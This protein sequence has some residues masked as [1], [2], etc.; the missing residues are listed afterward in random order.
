MRTAA[1]KDD[2]H[3][4]IVQFF[5]VCGWA[6]VD[7]SELKIGCH[8]FVSRAFETVAIKIDSDLMEKEEALMAQ[9]WNGHYRVV[10]TIN[11]IMDINQEFFGAKRIK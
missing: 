10:S 11:D 1:K 4:K 3:N 7:V 8:L 6:I 2:N 9:N 5:K